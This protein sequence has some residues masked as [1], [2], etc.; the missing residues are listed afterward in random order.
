[1]N[2]FSII[3]CCYNSES[4]ILSTLQALSELE[5]PS[6]F[7]I[8]LILVDNNCT[9]NT[10]MLASEFW[11]K[12]NS[13]FN[14][15]V[16]TEKN[17]GLS[18]A[19]VCGAKIA[20]Y[21]Y[22]VF[23]DDDNWINKDYLMVAYNLLERRNDIGVLGG[24]SVAVTDND[25]YFPDWFENEKSSYAV[26]KQL[27]FS[28]DAS[29]RKYLWGSGMIIRQ[30]IFKMIFDAGL[31]LLTDRKGSELDS[32]G[33]SEICSR[34]LLKGFTLYYD[35][36][37]FFKHYISPS[38]LT[39]TYLIRL[40]EGHQRAYKIL[41]CYWNY[42]DYCSKRFD[43]RFRVGVINILRL[44]KFLII[45]HSVNKLILERI[46]LSY[47]LFGLIS[48]TNY[49]KINQIALDLKSL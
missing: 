3:I 39:K 37:L 10:V 14:L 45:N 42:I 25:I 36:R 33:D 8:E 18:A 23:C 35:E 41:E 27:Q 19:R 43:I 47:K 29:F 32:G 40:T 21:K 2:G 7:Q 38:R 15:I 16:V 17:P 34:V 49:K 24:Q 44:I 1:M 26:G 12:I 48:N 46:L 28:G 6:E 30:S 22:L 11:I 13:K 20:K 9:D 31:S 5:I 4:R